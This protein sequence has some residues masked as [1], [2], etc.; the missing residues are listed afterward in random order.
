MVISL[1]A[2]P[3]SATRSA[4]TREWTSPCLPVSVWVCVCVCV[5]VCVS[6]YATRAIVSHNSG[7]W[8]KRT[9]FVLIAKQWTA[10][11]R[12]P[13]GEN[14]FCSNQIVADCPF[15][16]LAVCVCVFV[17][18]VVCG[19]VYGG[20]CVCGVCGGVYGGVCGGVY[21]GVCVCI[22]LCVTSVCEVCVRSV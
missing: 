15:A 19:G 22:E 11:D 17:Y 4:A 14:A 5:C 12:S 8:A 9:H 20:V 3:R 1:C 13:I 10:S 2:P 21:G 6:P 16:C 7:Q 18:G